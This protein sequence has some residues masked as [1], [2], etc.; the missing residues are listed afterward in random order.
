MF[1]QP[2]P[3]EKLYRESKQ[4]SYFLGLLT[5]DVV[6]AITSHII[7]H[8]VRLDQWL[9]SKTKNWIHRA[10]LR[11]SQC[12]RGNFPRAPQDCNKKRRCLQSM[13]SNRWSAT[14]V[15]RAGHLCELFLH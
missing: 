10:A 3:T 4:L 6:T 11:A 1:S 7:G 15:L 12:R 2:Q 8:K 14:G 9:L 13:K 5:P